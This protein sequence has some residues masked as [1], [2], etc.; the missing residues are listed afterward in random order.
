MKLETSGGLVRNSVRLVLAIAVALFLGLSTLAPAFAAGG[1]FSAI[2]GT[3]IDATTKAPIAGANIY[4]VSPS[5]SY[6][7]KT[8][9]KGFFT[10]LGMSVD[11]YTVTISAPGHQTHNL[12]GVVAFGDE[13]EALG[14]IALGTQLKTIAHVQSNSVTSAFQPNQTTDS[15]TISGARITETTGK[16]AATNENTLLLAVPGVTLTNAG[17]PTIRGATAREIGYQYD[18]VN[19]VEPFLGN[20]GSDGLYNAIGNVQVVEGAGNATQGSIGAGVINIIPKRGTYPGSMFF[21]A[22]VGGP[23]FNHQLDIEDGMA[24]KNGRFSNYISFNGQRY[25]P[26]FGNAGINQAAYLN[27]FQNQYISN[28]QFSDNFFYKFGHNQSK[29]L[30]VLYT[31]IQQV[32]TGILNAGGVFN[33][34]TNPNAAVYYPYDSLTQGLWQFLADPLAG[35]YTAAQYASLIGLSPGVPTTNQPISAPQQNF[36]LQTRFLKFEF[37]DSIDENTYLALRYYNWEQLQNSDDSYTLGPASGGISAQQSVGGPTVGVSGDLTRQIG[38]NLTVSLNGVFNV[39]HPIWNAYEPQLQALALGLS[40]FGANSQGISGADFLPGGYLSTQGVP[41]GTRIPSWGINYNGAF[42]Q[43]Y[44]AG[45]RFQYTPS[46]RVNFDLGVRY[47]GQNQHWFNQL[48]QYGQALPAAINPFDISPSAY[49][50]SVLYPHVVEP[51]LAVAYKMG[52]DSAIRFGYG[53][54]AV[55]ANAQSAGTPFHLYGLQ[56]FLNVAAKPGPGSECGINGQIQ[57]PV[58]QPGCT[59]YAQQLYW[60]GDNVE[61]PDVGNTFP[62]NYSNYDLSFSH[63]FKNGFAARLTP[64]YKLGTNLPDFTLITILPGGGEIFGTANQGFNRTTGV[65]FNLTTPVRRLGFSGFLAATYQNVL[66]T[67]PPLSINE[68]NVPLLSDA[69]VALG[70]IYRAGYVS[71]FSIRV[72]GTENLKHGFSITPIL[73]YDIGYPY[74]I[75][76]LIAGGFG[77]GGTAPYANVPQ[78]DFGAGINPLTGVQ[79]ISGS[80]LSTNYY[81]PSYPGTSQNPNIAAN[82]GTP[83]TS[84]NGG[85]LSQPNL[86]AD[87]TLQYKKN[88]N[89]F[90][91]QM[92][93]L[94]ANAY[95][96]SVPT[97]N[98]FYQPIATGVSGPQTNYNVCA[99]Q[100]YGTARGCTAQLPTNTYA[101]TNGAYLLSNGDFTGAPVLAPLQPFTIQVYYQKSL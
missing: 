67:T 9:A 35:G 33:A 7:A 43:D 60:A 92:L 78:V 41:A 65:E 66:S 99:A 28:N 2:H 69:T 86:E 42:F 63:Q 57:I 46:S 19:F 87:L 27:Y 29:S 5:G 23:N 89:T 93:N 48:G 62:A 73:Q 101:Y 94:F 10:I 11:T 24:T 22:E 75:G 59:T 37:D 97:V 31:N 54:S 40:A 36:S 100:G 16:L 74:S 79:N 4:A 91:V 3:V 39:L 56:P 98:P 68:T 52:N 84:A 88:G 45:I 53:R 49:T 32:G 34:A 70:N 44:G 51:R 61:A 55:F 81:D 72:G 47:E 82:R 8:D 20:N 90:G 15:Y 13:D 58:G 30:Q 25:T 38:S 96:N 26:Y 21:D 85:K 76:N 71:P 12:T 14:T 64:F 18:G 17:V 83:A 80:G 77:P 6:S 50:A 1:Q 95:L